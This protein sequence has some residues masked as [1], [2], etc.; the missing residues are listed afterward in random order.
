MGVPA[1]VRSSHDG[2]PLDLKRL[3]NGHYTVSRPPASAGKDGTP[4]LVELD[5]QFRTVGTG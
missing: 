4:G 3:A 2:W 1:Y 5:D